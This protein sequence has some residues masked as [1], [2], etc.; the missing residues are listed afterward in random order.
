MPKMPSYWVLIFQN[1]SN[2]SGLVC[3]AHQNRFEK[4]SLFCSLWHS[5]KGQLLSGRA[6]SR[7]F[8]EYLTEGIPSVNLI[9]WYECSQVL[10]LSAITSLKSG[11]FPFKRGYQ[12][13]TTCSILSSSLYAGI[14]I[15]RESILFKSLTLF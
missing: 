6:A 12:S 4:H 10:S 3:P 7:C 15:Y 1:V 13:R 2:S 11:D 9:V 14:T 5:H 8:Q